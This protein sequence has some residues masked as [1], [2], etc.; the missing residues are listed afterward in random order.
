LAN[1]FAECFRK[2]G[3]SES[4][5]LL[6]S[7]V[8]WRLFLF[9]WRLCGASGSWCRG[10]R[11][12]GG[13]TLA[14]YYFGNVCPRVKLEMIVHEKTDHL[15]VGCPPLSGNPCPVAEDE[16]IGVNRYV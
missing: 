8:V 4:L 15:G 11:G 1:S 7:P 9:G 5:I 10:F 12:I 2:P 13:R 14:E 3:S 16:G 6:F